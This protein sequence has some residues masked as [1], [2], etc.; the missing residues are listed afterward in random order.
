MTHAKFHFIRLMLT[1]I[2]GIWVSELPPRAWRTAEKAGPDWVNPDAFLVL[3]FLFYSIWR[4]PLPS[5]SQYFL[6]PDQNELQWKHEALRLFVSTYEAFIWKC[7]FCSLQWKHEALRLFVSTYEAF[8]WKCNFCSP[9][10]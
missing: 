1:L 10:T 2:F 6:M 9:G 3:K 4:E 7:N 8:I 5:S